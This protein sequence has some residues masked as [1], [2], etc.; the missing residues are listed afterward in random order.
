MDINT[1]FITSHYRAARWHPGGIKEWS[2]LEWA[3]AMCGEAGEAANAAKKLKR[4][5]GHI[6]SINEGDRNFTDEQR[7]QSQVIKECCDTILYALLTMA[8]AGC[9]DPEDALR[10]VFNQKSIE[11]GFPERI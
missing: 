8:R 1:I 4:L 7:A 5:E 11:Y 3:G 10:Q 2:A 9:T 6:A